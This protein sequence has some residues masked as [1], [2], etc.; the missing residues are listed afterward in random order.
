MRGFRFKTKT[1]NGL[2][3]RYEIHC[4]DETQDL[5]IIKL[6][7]SKEDIN[8]GFKCIKK[9]KW[10]NIYLQVM[11]IKYGSMATI[12]KEL[13]QPLNLLTNE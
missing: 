9:S 5:A 13:F 7:L 10:G 3:C 12:T 2:L 6:I 11:T 4:K 1:N 8:Y